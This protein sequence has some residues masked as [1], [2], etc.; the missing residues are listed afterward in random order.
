[1]DQFVG[2][3]VAVG[4]SFAPEGWVLCNG[5]VLPISQYEALFSLI[6][7]TFGGDG[8]S[9]FAVP[10]LRG[11]SPLGQGA[12]PGL[13]PYA[14]GQIGGTEEVVLNASQVAPHT[15]EVMAALATGTVSTPSL[16]VMLAN[17]PSADFCVYG[18]APADTSLHPAA[19]TPAN[20]NSQSHENRQPFNTVNYIM[21]TVGIY[22]TQA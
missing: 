13:S 5:Q 17:Q 7:T 9:N 10:D 18:L 2:Q 6:G 14:C 11:R 20:G 8:Q 4:F 16:D 15:H 1:M 19:I 22:P 3:V 21:S 12:S